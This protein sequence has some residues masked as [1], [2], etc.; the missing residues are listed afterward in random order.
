MER[1]NSFYLRVRQPSHKMQVLATV[2]VTQELARRY[3]HARCRAL[4]VA[5]AI[6]HK[7]ARRWA[8][9]SPL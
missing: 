9:G 2:M 1:I 3:P 5:Q 6:A 8:V 7:E 4:W